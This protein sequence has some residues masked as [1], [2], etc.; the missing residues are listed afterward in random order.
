MTTTIGSLA[1]SLS[2]NS[3]NFNGSMAKVDRSL[4][5]MGSELKAVQAQGKEYGNSL[6]GLRSKKDILNRTLEAQ[7]LKLTETRKKFDELSTSESRNEAQ[8]ERQAKKVNDAQAAYNRLQTELKQVDSELKKQNSSWFLMSERLT[9]V[10]PKLKSVGDGMTSVG[11]DLTMKV[12]APIVGLGI[13]SAKVAIDFEA[14]MDRVGAIAG[15]TS[16]DMDKLSKSALDLGANTSKSASEVALGMENMAAMG[17]EVNEILGAMPGIISAAEASGADMAQTADVVASALNAFGLEATEAS[18]VAD[19]LAQSANQSAADITDLQFAFKYAAPIANTLGI[20]ME[21]LAA[22][23]G[24]MTDAGIKG[25][26]AGTT[27]RGGLIALAHPAEKTSKLMKTMGITVE[28]ANKKFV[29]LSPLI[30]NITESLKG[31]SDVQKLATLAQLVGTEAASGFLTLIEAGPAQI[32]KMTTSLENSAGASAKTAAIMKDNLK[33]ALEELGGTL[34]TAAITVGGILTPSIKKASE[35]VK[36]LVEDFQTLSPETQKNILMFAGIAAAIGPVLV[37]GGTLISSVGTITTAIG[38]LTGGVAGAGGALAILTG[39]IGWTVAGLGLLATAIGIGT[40]AYKKSNDVNIEVLETKQ[41]EIAKNDELI[42]SFD[43]LRSENELSNVQML[44]YLDIQAELAAT[45]A[46]DKVKALKDE[47]AALL[48]ESTLTN[49][50]M[51]EFLVLNQNVIDTAPSTV[52]A[53]SSQ[54]EAFATNTLALKELN[55]EKARELENSARDTLKNALE[56]ETKLIKEQN[57]LVDERVSIE[58]KLQA[59][60]QEIIST[61]QEI[62]KREAEILDLEKQKN[63]AS[64]EQIASLENKI[65]REQDILIKN[66]AQYEEA[67]HMLSTYG[68]QFDERGKLLKTNEKELALLEEAQFKYEE[69]I[70]TQAGITAE[71]GRGLEKIDEELGKLDAQKSKFSELLSSGKINTQEYQEQNAKIDTQIDKLENAKS[72]LELINTVAGKTVYKEMKFTENPK[73]FLNTLDEKLGKKVTKTIDFSYSYPKMGGPLGNILNGKPVGEDFG[74]GLTNGM[75]SKKSAVDASAASLGN[76][77]LRSLSK[78]LDRKSPSKKTYAIGVDTGKGYELGI[79][80]RESASAKVAA[81]I[82][83]ATLNELK[84][85]TSEGNRAINAE[86]ADINKKAKEE[87]TKIEERAEED[88]HQIRVNAKSRKRNLTSNE[89]FRIERLEVDSVSKVK[90]INEK[91]VADIAKI[92]ENASKDKLDAVKNLI[93]DKKNLEEL[94]LIDE[95]NIW[96]KSVE[97]FKEGTDEK[98]A[99][100]I[101]YRNAIEKVNSEITSIN[102]TYSNKIQSINEDLTEDILNAKKELAS[103]SKSINDE[104]IADEERVNDEYE[105]AFEN[106]YN[107]LRNFAGLF[108]KFDVTPKETGLDLLGNLKSQVDGFKDWEKAIDELSTKAI[109]EGLLAELSEMGPKALPQLLALNSMTDE[110]L[111]EYSALFREKSELARNET[112]E[113]LKGMKEDTQRQLSELRL[114]ANQELEYLKLDTFNR[115][116]EM[117]LTANIQLGGLQSEWVLKIQDITKTTNDEFLTLTQ[118]GMNAGQN[119][120]DGLKSM[121]PA[122]VAQ[123]TEIARA[124]NAALKSTLGGS[125]SIP[126]S[127]QQKSSSNTKTSTASINTA[128]NQNI[129]HISE[130]VFP[131]V[132]TVEEMAKFFNKRTVNS[133]GL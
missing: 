40:I 41:K 122:L 104:L 65:R 52:K 90:K 133:Y 96:R 131:A 62:A 61:S 89:L 112:E 26:Q 44:R 77:A 83:N 59:S 36:G 8:V 73:N 46:P 110:Q 63:G 51:D 75:N 129:Y 69:I 107:S 111:N 32:D 94:S 15:A 14:Q 34:E 4:R 98:K 105:N 33:G 79:A 9:A 82:A 67:T 30:K 81:N 5:V 92:H 115:I 3:D 58:S 128:A 88:A 124:V 85:V 6:D 117:R 113:S 17:F 13:A 11:K 125:V 55:A 37:I 121:Q 109:D 53:I 12:T 70:L 38:G 132:K 101:E 130:A 23:V 68:K 21:E 114:L 35:T 54:G 64:L 47:Q 31:Q 76:T 99:A 50:Q 66:R 20:S 2:L 108:D 126:N 123:A 27:L 22:S 97:L 10:G 87:S 95:A 25:E 48:K 60:Q 43:A 103:K 120:L 84:K 116:N 42:E 72:K 18:R 118:I 49:D 24:I 91:A 71:K 93:N 16:T 39:P 45:N 86:I 28:G 1:V 100:Q 119:L 127:S 106:R 29:G 102:E 56:Q 78:S 80:S 7:A 57:K 19:V 74:Q